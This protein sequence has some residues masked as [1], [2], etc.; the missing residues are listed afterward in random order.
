[1]SHWQ[2]VKCRQHS[3]ANDHVTCWTLSRGS[4]LALALTLAAVAATVNTRFKAFKLW[5]LPHVCEN[6]VGI[7]T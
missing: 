6:I 3:H 7:S 5:P 4:Q 2:N 1:M